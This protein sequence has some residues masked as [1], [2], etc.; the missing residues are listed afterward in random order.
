MTFSLKGR[1]PRPL[2]DRAVYRQV[3]RRGASSRAIPRD[4]ADENGVGGQRVRSLLAI[5]VSVLL[6]SACGGSGGSTDNTTGGS[7]ASLTATVNALNNA[8]IG[9][10]ILVAQDG[11]TL[12][13]FDEDTSGTPTCYDACAPNWPPYTVTG[14]PTSSA[15]GTVGT[16][17]RTDGKMQVTFN[18]KP[19]Y[20][21][22][23]DDAPGEAYGDGRS[24]TW[25]V[26]PVQ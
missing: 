5:A 7:S 15:G 18:G 8:A 20:F 12:Y 14:Q 26:V 23:Q 10:K 21:Y 13:T 4:R 19:L 6:V 3:Y 11:H 25:H 17:A 2:G 24:G 16:V 22:A 1:R 9:G